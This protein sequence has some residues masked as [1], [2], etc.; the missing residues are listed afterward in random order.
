MELM[1]DKVWVIMSRDRKVIAKGTGKDKELV[2]VD[3]K[4]CRRKILT[5]TSE[6]SAKQGMNYGYLAMRTG[7]GWEERND[8][9]IVECS[10]TLNV[11]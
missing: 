3:D 11:N 6:R 9:E 1:N 8:L 2:S 4:S 5:Y 7:D 10:M